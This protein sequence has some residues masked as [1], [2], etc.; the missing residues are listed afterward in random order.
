MKLTGQSQVDENIH[1]FADVNWTAGP[2]RH[3]TSG[4]MVYFLS[5]VLTTWI[6]TQLTVTLSTAEAELIALGM[7]V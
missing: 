3:S 4:G 2:S 7:A 1:T 5:T 6:R